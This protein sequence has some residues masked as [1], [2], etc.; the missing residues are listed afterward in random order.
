MRFSRGTALGQISGLAPTAVR[1]SMA[2]ACRL[3][4]MKALLSDEWIFESIRFAIASAIG[5]TSP[6][7]LLGLKLPQRNAHT[8]LRYDLGM[9]EHFPFLTKKDRRPSP[10]FPWVP[11][12]WPSGTLRPPKSVRTDPTSPEYFLNQIQFIPLDPGQHTQPLQFPT[13]HRRPFQFD[14]HLTSSD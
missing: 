1:G 13:A 11:G 3:P 9:A 14:L 5:V 7:F 2:D 10:D 4:C 8:R 12:R 6:D